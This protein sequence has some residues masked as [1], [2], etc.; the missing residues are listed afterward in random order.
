[1]AKIARATNFTKFYTWKEERTRR[2]SVSPQISQKSQSIKQEFFMLC[3]IC[4]NRILQL[5]KE[6]GKESLKIWQNA[7]SWLE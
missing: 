4:N 1:M 5:E 6:K 7:T 2:A 3:D